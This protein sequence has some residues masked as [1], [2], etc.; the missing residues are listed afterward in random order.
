[1]HPGVSRAIVLERV[2]RTGRKHLVGYVLLRDGEYATA[3]ELRRFL[4]KQ[5]PAASVPGIIIV[6]DAM[7]VGAD[8]SLDLSL[9]HDP[10]ALA[11][12]HIAP[13]SETERTIATIWKDTLG[14]ERVGVRDNFFDI[15]GHSLL[16]VRAAMQLNRAV[17][18]RLN[19]ATMVMQTLEQ[20]AAEVDRQLVVKREAEVAA[21]SAPGLGT[22][23]SAPDKGSGGFLRSLRKAVVGGKE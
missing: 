19:Q 14:V 1:M 5:L 7:P 8:D 12:D 18:V 21:A 13:R 3:S 10:F 4:K 22:A 6:I 2:D 11:D 15:G 16:A 17:G 9:L 23:A 20:V